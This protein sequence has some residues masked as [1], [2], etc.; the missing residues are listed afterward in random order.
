M[1]NEFIIRKGF[2]SLQD[3]ELT[4]SLN[5][6]GNIVADGTVEASFASNTSTAISGAFDSVSSSLSSRITDQESFSSSLDDSFATDSDLN[7]VSSSVDSLNAATSSYALDNQISGSTTSLSSSLASELLKNTTD[8]LTGDLTVT[9]TITAQEFHTEFVSA[10]IT[11]ESGSHKFG[12]S[13][14]DIHEFTGSVNVSN[15]SGGITGSYNFTGG[16]FTVQGDDA[17]LNLNITSGSS[18]ADLAEFRFQTDGG[19]MGRFYMHKG[20][21]NMYLGPT[22]FPTSSLYLQDGTGTVMSITGSSVGI[23]LTSPTAKLDV[24]QE[25]RISYAQGNQYRTRITN[26]D[27][28]TR[29]LSDGQQSSIIFGITGDVA[30]GT[31][32]EAMRLN[33]EGNVG[34][35]DNIGKGKLAIKTSGT[36]TTDSNDGDFSG[37]NILLKTDN[38]ATNAVG[39]GIVWMKG[40]S[41]GRKLS[42]ITNY[43]YGDADQS[44]LNFY[45]QETSS[46]SSASLTEAMRID[47]SGRVGIGIEDPAANLEVKEN[48]YVSHPNA[49]ELTFRLDNYGTTGT[50]AGSSL[51]LFNQ[52]GDTVIKLDSRSGST[53]HTYFNQGGNVGIGNANPL[54]KLQITSGDSGASSPWSNA[55]ELILESAGNA[56]L[57]FQTPNTGAATIAFQDPES[58]QAGFIQYL[59][60]DNALRFATNGNNERMRIDSSGRV[61]I[62]TTDIEETLTI[63]KHDGGDGTIVG[64]R[65]DASFSQFELVT[66]DS[67]VSW[68]L[69]TI[70]ARNMYF[71]T[72]GSERMRIDS[73]GNVGISSTSPVYKLDV[74]G[75]ARFTEQIKVEQPIV[76]W[77]DSGTKHYTHLATFSG[78]GSGASALIINTNIPGHNQSGNANMLSFRIVGYAYGSL[79]LIDMMVGCYA[80]ENNYYSAWWTGTCQTNWVDNVYVYTNSSGKVAFQ[81]GETTDTLAAEIAI[82]DFVQGFGNVNTSYA[83]SWSCQAVTTLPTQ[84]QKTT[85]GY[86]AVAPDIYED[87]TFHDKVGIGPTNPQFGLSMSQGTGDGNRIGWN[88]GAGDKRASIICSSSTDALQFHTGTSDTERMRITSGGDFKVIDGFTELTRGSN[89]NQIALLTHTGTVPYGMQVRYTGASPNTTDNY[90]FIGSDSSANRIIIWG[91]GNIQNSNNSYGA[92]SDEKL[93]ENIVDATPKLD[94]LMKVK[95]RNYNFIGQEDKQIGVIAQEIENVFPNLVE[96]TKDPE[97]EETTKSV[98]YSVLVPI[99]LKAIQELKADNDSLKARI[100]ALEG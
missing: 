59:H 8:T 71:T 88:D 12:D 81:I 25:T 67:Q 21:K 35:N 73:S 16:N 86:K 92:I 87:V 45:V 15:S 22:Y 100:E 65:S 13:Y 47:N 19:T 34:I 75:D 31:A 4:G 24:L 41:D 9:G 98:K 46:G 14:D 39:S 64:L 33:W 29:I 93:K 17:D 95:I 68:G 7:L 54:A 58:V 62:G 11:Y 27:G 43:I 50:D 48:L 56:G 38:T 99:M 49:E 91:N 63:A 37:V 72:N 70:G 3:S 82:T 20:T 66:K 60:A 52:S 83:D 10:S 42:A 30:N 40:G 51:R 76:G 53:R 32:S 97:N 84:T 77:S 90:F 94:D 57:A 96:D 69:Q 85:L 1:A 44:G 6:S 74:V 61:G 18:L 55:D 78:Y 36:F 80:G 5:L 23:G 79:G 2:K 89:G 28:N 26:T